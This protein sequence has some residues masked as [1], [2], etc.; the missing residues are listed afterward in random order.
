MLKPHVVAYLRSLLKPIAI[1]DIDGVTL[2]NAHRLHHIVQNFDGKQ[3]NKVPGDWEQFHA[4]ADQDPPGAA[5]EIVRTF[6]K[7]H[8]IVFV[9]ARVAFGS[10]RSALEDKLCR[11]YGIPAEFQD[12]LLPV[13]MREPVKTVEGDSINNHA[14]YKRLVIHWMREQGLD[15]TVGIDDSLAICQMFKEE[16]LLSLRVHNHVPEEAL[17]R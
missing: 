15:P 3:M 17:W 1:F 10:K 12:T 6:A 2:D 13:I 5:F 8:S 14:E 7:T 9:T 11:M 4:L 16:G